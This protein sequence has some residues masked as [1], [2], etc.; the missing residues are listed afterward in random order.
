MPVKHLV[1]DSDIYAN[2][3]YIQGNNEI[4]L[5][6]KILRFKDYRCYCHTTNFIELGRKP[7]TYNVRD[8]LIKNVHQKCVEVFSDNK[9]LDWLT[10][11]FGNGVYEAYLDYLDVICAT[12]KKQLYKNVYGRID[13]FTRNKQINRRD[14]LKILHE[15]DSSDKG[16]SDLG[17]RKSYILL[18]TLA[19][20]YGADNCYIF[21]SDDRKARKNLNQPLVDM[22]SKIFSLGLPAIFYKLYQDGTEKQEFDSYFTAYTRY[23][24]IANNKNTITIGKVTDLYRLQ[25]ISPNEFY[26]TLT[27]NN[28]ILGTNGTLLENPRFTYKKLLA[29]KQQ[30]AA[31]EIKRIK[32]GE[33]IP[34]NARESNK[35]K[36]YP[37]KDIYKIK[38][39]TP[40]EDEI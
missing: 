9:I 30:L 24:A 38:G 13:A 18:Q 17:E 34:E 1:I 22:S 32:N 28:F 23:N 21:C 37:P 3:Y 31:E 5:S 8:N 15:C 26:Q 6:D 36:I 20:R 4:P 16:Q 10:D 14:F 29:Q 39:F 25:E 19:W 35:I 27:S 40:M 12:Y 11:R 2:S 33:S 7:I